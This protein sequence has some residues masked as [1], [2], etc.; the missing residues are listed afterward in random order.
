MKKLK[1]SEQVVI[2]LFHFLIGKIV[3]VD[4]FLS[5]F[6]P[7]NNNKINKGKRKVYIQEIHSFF[8][9]LLFRIM[10]ISLLFV[11]LS[12]DS[13]KEKVDVCLVLMMV[14]VLI[15]ISIHSQ[16]CFELLLLLFSISS[17][18]ALT[19]KMLNFLSNGY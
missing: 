11:G 5:L 7:S 1:N 15:H 9:F 6:L 2:Y 10:F 12:T 19:K 17:F 4:F 14:L 18:P 13:N 3:I 16:F 8:F